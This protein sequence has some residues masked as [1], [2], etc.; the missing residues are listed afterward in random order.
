L[1]LPN[2]IYNKIKLLRTIERTYDIKPLDVDFKKQGEITMTDEVF[3]LFKSLFRTQ[4]KKPTDY[5]EL[6]KL[7]VGIIKSITRNEIITSKRNKKRTGGNRDENDYKI[8]NDFIIK[9]LELNKYKN[10]NMT[11]FSKVFIEMFNIDVTPTETQDTDFID[12][13]LDM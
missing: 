13:G 7:Y 1:K 11:G 5:K 6:K 3:T 4:K 10:K 2:N 8:D 9:H 12:N